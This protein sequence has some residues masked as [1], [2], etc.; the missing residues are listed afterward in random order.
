MDDKKVGTKV[1]KE[2]VEVVAN[3]IIRGTRKLEI[4]LCVKKG[5]SKKK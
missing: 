1:E 2:E 3:K 5:K 4:R